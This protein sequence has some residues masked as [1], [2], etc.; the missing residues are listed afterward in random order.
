MRHPLTSPT[1]ARLRR[2]SARDLAVYASHPFAFAALAAT[3]RLPQLRLG[4]TVIVHDRD[5][6]TEALTGIPLDRLAAGTTGGRRP[7]TC[8]PA[9]SPHSHRSGIRCC[10]RRP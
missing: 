5:Q 4:T 2:A 1:P 10:S 3:S 9:R 7:H 6:Y 8:P